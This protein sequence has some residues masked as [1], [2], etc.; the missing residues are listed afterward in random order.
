MQT[1]FAEIFNH[2]LPTSARKYNHHTTS[3]FLSLII[4]IKYAGK[5]GVITLIPPNSVRIYAALLYLFCPGVLILQVRR[6]KRETPESMEGTARSKPHGS[7]LIPLKENWD[8]PHS[9]P[10][11]K[12]LFL[13]SWMC[14]RRAEGTLSCPD[15]VRP[16]TCRSDHEKQ[17]FSCD[18][19][20]L[21]Y[22]SVIH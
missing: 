11:S 20:F 21:L 2:S 12:T 7:S 3:H 8:S 22:L 17:T 1:L 5:V 15:E 13:C 4:S 10:T 14:L 18:F 19:K 16:T 9:A 6:H